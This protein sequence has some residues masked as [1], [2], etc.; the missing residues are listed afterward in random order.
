LCRKYAIENRCISKPLLRDEV[1]I[2]VTPL[3]PSSP[4]GDLTG[5]GSEAKCTIQEN[6]HQN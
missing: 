2:S 1:P 6:Q 3:L 5:A 4:E